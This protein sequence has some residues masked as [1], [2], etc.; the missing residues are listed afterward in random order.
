MDATRRIRGAVIALAAAGLA[1]GMATPPAGFAGEKTPFSA[2]DG[3]DLA[4]AAALAWADDARLVYVEND[5]AVAGGEAARWGYL[6]RSDSRATSRAYSVENG[7]IRTATDA[8]FDFDAPPLPADWIDS[9]R[10]L[11][12]ADEAGG[13]SY[14]TEEGGRV[15]ALF[16]VRGVMDAE[17]PDVPTWAVVYESDVAPGLWLVIDARDGKV[18]KRWRG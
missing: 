6:Y 7:E 12:S 18:V 5:E 11:A 9:A 2:R 15:R 14:R 10:A 13:N 1:G 3:E 16:L 8:P 17:N 4:T